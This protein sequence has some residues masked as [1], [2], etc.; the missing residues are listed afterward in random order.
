MGLLASLEL[1]HEIAPC[2][3]MVSAARV[4]ET[5][6]VDAALLE[7]HPESLWPSSHR[8]KSSVAKN[9]LPPICTG[10]RPG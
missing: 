3:D 5:R 1:G 8:C 7:L 4:R 9:T 10:G 2:G 6:V